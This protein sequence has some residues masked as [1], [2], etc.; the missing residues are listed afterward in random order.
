[1][2]GQQLTAVG[3][4]LGHRHD[5]GGEGQTGEGANDHGVPEGAGGGDQ[6]LLHGV[7]GASRGR[8]DGGG[9]HTG[10]VGEQAT[11]HAVLHGNHDGGAYETTGSRLIAEGAVENATNGRPHVLGMGA[12]QNNAANH[13]NNRHGGH[14]GIA[15]AGNPL[16]ATNQHSSHHTGQY[17]PRYPAGHV[18]STLGQHTRYGVRLGDVTDTEGRHSGEDCENHPEPLALQATLQGIHGATQHIAGGIPHTVTNSQQ[19]LGIAGSHTQHTGHHAPEHSTGTTGRHGHSHTHNVA[20]THV[21]REGYHE[22]AEVRYLAFLVLLLLTEVVLQCFEKV[23]LRK[24]QND[25]QVQV[26]AQQAEEQNIPPQKS[27]GLVQK[28]VDCVHHIDIIAY[29]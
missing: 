11:A 22:R 14:A 20:R 17:Q 19:A 29:R 12:E 25:G 15:H 24:S 2:V 18:Q 1:M 4:N 10:L 7:I 5:G 13:V 6:S 3:G 9:T 8:D 26:R 28:C 16:Q 21:R 27:T 23:K